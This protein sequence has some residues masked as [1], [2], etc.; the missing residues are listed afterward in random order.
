TVRLIHLA[1][2]VGLGLVL[3]WAIGRPTRKGGMAL[4]VGPTPTTDRDA[5]ST[6]WT[7]KSIHPT[8]ETPAPSRLALECCV[9]FLMMLLLS[10]MSSKPHFL[11]LLLPG[12]CLAR[13]AI[14]ERRLVLGAF[15]VAAAA[16]GALSIRDLWG[17]DLS[18]AALW[19][20]S[21]TWSTLLLLFG[22]AYALVAC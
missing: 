5:D 18:A 4:H 21:V 9:V 17:N 13:L 19:W 2:S 12:F 6:P 16:V 7:D 3:L 22:C 8:S 20:G 1:L 10:P 15:V 11:T 14:G